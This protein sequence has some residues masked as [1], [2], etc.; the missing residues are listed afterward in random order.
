VPLL[1]AAP[2]PMARGTRTD[3]IAELVDLYPTL[4]E[5]A[6][7]PPADGLEGTSLTPVLR[8]PQCEWGAVATS[9]WARPG[10]FRPCASVT[11]A[12]IAR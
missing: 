10:W 5:L 12:A 11:M 3:R 4:C 8:D 9:Q 6:G 7:L 1:I 2:G